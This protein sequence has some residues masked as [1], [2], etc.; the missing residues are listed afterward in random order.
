MR[1][2][3]S[4]HTKTDEAAGSGRGTC[5]ERIN[6]PRLRVV[7]C[8]YTYSSSDEHSL[9]SSLYPHLAPPQSSFTLSPARVMPYRS[10]VQH[11]EPLDTELG[12]EEFVERDVSE[13]TSE[14]ESESKSDSSSEMLVAEPAGDMVWR[15]KRVDSAS[16]VAL[17]YWVW[18]TSRVW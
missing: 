17:S 16:R 9:L 10:H 1:E 14:P 15:A 11:E 5:Y 7:F 3:I 2:P 13:G 8:S 18:M 12:D 4:S 6:T